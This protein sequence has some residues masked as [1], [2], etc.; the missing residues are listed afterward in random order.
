MRFVR[1]TQTIRVINFYDRLMIEKKIREHVIDFYT[2]YHL[3]SVKLRQDKR[4]IS[5]LESPW[6]TLRKRVRI[7][8]IA[9]TT[10]VSILEKF[11]CAD[12]RNF[13]YPNNRHRIT[14]RGA[15][16]FHLYLW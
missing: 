4:L 1:Q 11:T 14:E 15:S 9:L 16:E 7:L 10:E 6:R 12:R 8:E 13:T 2:W 3:R 5:L